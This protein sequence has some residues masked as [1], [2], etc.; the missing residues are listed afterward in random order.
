MDL[1]SCPLSGPQLKARLGWVS[2]IGDG[3]GTVPV[4][5][6]AGR[7]NLQGGQGGGKK[8]AALTGFST[9]FPILRC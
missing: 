6:M 5:R 9:I 4:V 8:S 7:I 3:D 2:S 1:E